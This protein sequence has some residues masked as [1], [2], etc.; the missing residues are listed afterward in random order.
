MEKIFD[1]SGYHFHV[2]TIDGHKYWI[3]NELAH[4]FDY[5]KAG[6][7]LSSMNKE[8]VHTIVLTKENGLVEIKRILK[9][10]SL[11]NKTTFWNKNST[12]IAHMILVREDTLQKYLTLYT[13]KLDAKEVGKK[14]YKHFTKPEKKVEKVEKKEN[15]LQQSLRSEVEALELGSEFRKWYMKYSNPIMFLFLLTT[16]STS[17][18]FAEGKGSVSYINNSCLI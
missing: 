7:M 10:V 4:A 12:Y 14:L 8:D 6:N 18:P 13:R 11:L 3:G 16:K 5:S 9:E 2:L 17:I 15:A 1:T